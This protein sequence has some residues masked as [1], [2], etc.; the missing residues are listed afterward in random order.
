MLITVDFD[1][2]PEFK[3]FVNGVDATTSD[4][5][6]TKTAFTNATQGLMIGEWHTG[7]YSPFLGGI[8]EFSIWSGVA[9]TSTDVTSIYNSGVPNNL[10]DSNVVATAPTTWVR[11]DSST[12]DG[13]KW[14]VNDENSSYQ[15]ESNNMTS[16][17]RTSDVPT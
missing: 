2:D 13:S 7:K 15:L 6:S 16:A 5:M 17:S 9:L 4:N 12:W 3:C 8:D 1:A 14:T 11:S 10:N